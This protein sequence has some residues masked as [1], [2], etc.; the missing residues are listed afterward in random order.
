[1]QVPISTG[2]ASSALG[3]GV[4]SSIQYQQT[5]VILK[6]TPRVNDNGLV[7]L[8]IDQEV[9]DVSNTTSSSLDSPT[10]QERKIVTSVAVQDG[11]TISLGGLIKNSVTKSRNRLPLLGDI[12]V[13][14]Q[15]FGSTGNIIDRTEL[16]VFLTP[17]V[18][19][20]PVDADAIVKELRKDIQMAEPPPPPPVPSPPKPARPRHGA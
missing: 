5:G 4:V 7:L 13:L 1:D 8:D 11:E 12:P 2:T 18:V 15:L 16:V 20:A 9:S 19:R 3:G 10:I 6:V 14:G 17:H